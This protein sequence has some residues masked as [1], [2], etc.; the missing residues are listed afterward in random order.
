LARSPRTLND[1]L[2]AF[3]EEIRIVRRLGSV[4]QAVTL[5]RLSGPSRTT[6]TSYQNPVINPS[7]ARLFARLSR[8]STA[9]KRPKLVSFLCLNDRVLLLHGSTCRRASTPRRQG[10]LLSAR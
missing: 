9:S 3:D 1:T 8:A 2:T 10:S 4:L 5:C 6:P 7:Y